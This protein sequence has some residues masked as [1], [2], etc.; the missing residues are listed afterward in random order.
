MRNISTILLGACALASATASHASWQRASSTH[1]VIYADESRGDLLDYATRLE[2][3]DQ[4]VRHIRNMD[5]PAVGDGNRLTVFVVPSQSDVGRLAGDKTG[6]IAGFYQGRAAGS[7]A[8]VPREIGTGR[9]GDM[10]PETVFFHEYAHHLMFSDLTRPFPEWLVEGFAEFM[11]TAMFQK[12]GAVGIGLAP[13]F[14]AYGLFNGKP[15]A[16]EK[17]LA[18][19]YGK[20]DDSQ[21][22]SLYGRGWLLTHYLNFSTARRGQLETYVGAIAKGTDPLAAARTAF[23]DL[24]A[25]DRELDHYLDQSRLTYVKIDHRVFKPVEIDVEALTPGAAAVMN[26]RIRSKVGVDRTTAEPLAARVRAIET[27]FPGDPLVERTLA[28][29]EIDAGHPA[30]SEAAAD[31]ALKADPRSTEA[32]LFKGR[33]IEAGKLPARFAAARKWFITANKIDKEDPKPLMDFYLSYLNEGERPNENAIAALHYASELAPQDS[34]LRMSSAAAFVNED[35]L[36][37]AGRV[38]TSVAYDPHGGSLAIEARALL[39]R[40]NAGDLVGALKVIASEHGREP[41]PVSSK[42]R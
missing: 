35:K 34:G 3:F 18:G 22:E 7:L 13:Q 12:D 26:D 4:A 40:V 37:D 17:M 27:R 6:F 8:I 36:A 28:E 9:K 32:M 16:L 41:I 25:L 15:L 23:G 30:A 5:D 33:A 19:N 10:S 31:R 1:F 14:R 42:A 20:L 21:R 2:K 39:E 11:S 29:A 24:K 38:L